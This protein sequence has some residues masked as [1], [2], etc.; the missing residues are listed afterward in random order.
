[1]L[2]HYLDLL[3]IS[4]AAKVCIVTQPIFLSGLGCVTFDDVCGTMFNVSME[5]LFSSTEQSLVYLHEQIRNH[6]KM[7][8]TVTGRLAGLVKPGCTLLDEDGFRDTTFAL[9]NRAISETVRKL[10][11]LDAQNYEMRN[12]SFETMKRS[13]SGNISET[14]IEATSGRRLL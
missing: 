12:P 1:M 6:T 8:T 14:S 13:L 11:C 10:A 7:Q 3:R 5:W 9:V 2:S 4:H